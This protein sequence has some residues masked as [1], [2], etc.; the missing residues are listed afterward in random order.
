MVDS[1]VE[2][3][4]ESF[5]CIDVMEESTASIVKVDVNHLP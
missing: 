2:T 4:L 5:L 3:S 1:G